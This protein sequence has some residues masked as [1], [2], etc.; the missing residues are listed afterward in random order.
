MPAYRARAADG[1]PRAIAARH[2]TSP[3]RRASSAKTPLFTTPKDAIMSRHFTVTRTGLSLL[4]AFT[5]AAVGCLG[6]PPPT[7][8]ET[9]DNASLSAAACAGAAS[10]ATGVTYAT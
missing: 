10:W 7:E 8:A 2:R 5:T 6:E 1:T 9:S 4:V 3:R